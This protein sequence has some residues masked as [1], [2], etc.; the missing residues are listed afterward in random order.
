MSRRAGRNRFFCFFFRTSASFGTF[1]W[2]ISPRLIAVRRR[3]MKY[4]KK[5]QK[6]QKNDA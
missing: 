5:K 6:K 3:K 2:S 1:D 4:Q